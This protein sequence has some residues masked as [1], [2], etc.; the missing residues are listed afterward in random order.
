MGGLGNNL[1]HLG[2]IAT[3]PSWRRWFFLRSTARYFWVVKG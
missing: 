1:R 2:M 3:S